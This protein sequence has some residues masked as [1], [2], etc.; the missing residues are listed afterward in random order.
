MIRILH[1]VT[2]LSQTGGDYI[3]ARSMLDYLASENSSEMA[4]H[5]AEIQSHGTGKNESVYDDLGRKGVQFHVIPQ[6]DTPDIPCFYIA[7][8]ISQIVKSHDIDIVHTHT[9]ISDLIAVLVKTGSKNYLEQLDVILKG[10]DRFLW[11]QI[12]LSGQSL[13]GSPNSNFLYLDT[14]PLEEA[15]H[16]KISQNENLKIVS[17]K[18][19]SEFK[20]VF[21]K[22]QLGTVFKSSEDIEA[23]SNVNRVMQRFVSERA[24][25]VITI[26]SEAHLEWRQY[27]ASTDYIPVSIVDE[28]IPP[29][30][31]QGGVTE[32]TGT[33]YIFAGR[34]SGTKRPDLL[35]ES[36]CAHLTAFP[37]DTLTIVGVGGLLDHCKMIAGGRDEIVFRGHLSRDQLFQEM[38]QKDALCLF[39]LTE[40]Q[41]LVVQEAM[42]VGLAVLATGVGT[43]LEMVSDGESGILITQVTKEAIVGALRRFS[44]T[45]KSEQSAMGIMSRE[46]I[47]KVGSAVAS[48]NRHA[49]LYRRLTL[50][51]KT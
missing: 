24:D 4:F 23:A 11:D 18:H 25:H 26:G 30:Q 34:I 42:C 36:F 38:A 40:G 31:H 22:H 6:L 33:H 49:D 29:K 41:P 14:T 51:A 15:G 50:S 10:K 35:V 45:A 12:V 3:Y 43:I 19:Q 2:D 8:Q 17:T 46:R 7:D 1:L 47:K 5:I 21:Y 44:S 28:N 27:N 48:Y 9:F 32:G 13:A 39:S 16:R 20:S 37:N